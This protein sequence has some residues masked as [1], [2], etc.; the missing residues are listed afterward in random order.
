MSRAKQ[1]L[2]LSVC[3]LSSPGWRRIRHQQ[4]F[5]LY[6][7]LLYP[8]RLP[9]IIILL[10]LRFITI[11]IFLTLYVIFLGGGVFGDWAEYRRVRCIRYWVMKNQ[12]DGVTVRCLASSQTWSMDWKAGIV[13]NDWCGDEVLG[14]TYADGTIGGWIIYR[15][16]FMSNL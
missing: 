14:F 1:R 16:I 9:F 10:R 3:Y 2:I 6:L 7:L 12:K 13:R 8:F 4:F 15:D 5:F 11:Y